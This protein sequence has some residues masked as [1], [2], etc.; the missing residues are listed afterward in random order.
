MHCL[1][2]Q[3]SGDD[4]GF[5]DALH[6]RAVRHQLLP[7]VQRAA[8]LAHRI[9]GTAIPTGWQRGGAN[10]A[11]FLRRLTARNDW[12]QP[13]R[14]ATQMGFY[15]RSHAMRMPPMMLARHLWVKWRGA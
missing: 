3:F 1:L 8:R 9:Y 4:A 11:L 14:P 12:G 10:D 6:Q 5:W 15:V 13:T 2:G 7:V